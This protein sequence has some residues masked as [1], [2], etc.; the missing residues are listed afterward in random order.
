MRGGNQITINK[1][2]MVEALREYFEKRFAR[3]YAPDVVDVFGDKPTEG[4]F[5][6]V[7]QERIEETD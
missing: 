6:V 2:T 3:G 1:A 4:F 5:T 7:T